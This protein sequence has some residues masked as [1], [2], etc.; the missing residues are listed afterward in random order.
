MSKP[1]R[2]EKQYFFDDELV[3]V[4]LNALTGLASQLSVVQER[5]DTVERVLDEHGSA[6]IEQIESYEPDKQAAAERM[7][8]RMAIV[9]AALDPFKA[10]F[11]QLGE[12]QSDKS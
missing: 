12:K 1:K 10:H 11:S 5:L 3:D 6:T 7:A 2:L 9:Q 4:V 8:A